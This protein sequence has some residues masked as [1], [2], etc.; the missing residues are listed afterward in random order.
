MT[1]IPTA[2]DISG[3]TLAVVSFLENTDEILFG[4]DV[5]ESSEGLT[6]LTA[7]GLSVSTKQ[8]SDSN[9]KNS[10][11]TLLKTSE[12]IWE[13][14]TAEE[15]RRHFSVVLE[16]REDDTP[17]ET[18]TVVSTGEVADDFGS[19][20]HAYHVTNQD[21]I[22]KKCVILMETGQESSL[23]AVHLLHLWPVSALD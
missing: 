1:T 23:S 17:V 5:T 19:Q 8:P 18:F 9:K 6:W 22:T 21:G 7:A 16:N 10:S 15:A 20:A 3:P 4:T 12:A 2:A 13:L 11:L 14:Q